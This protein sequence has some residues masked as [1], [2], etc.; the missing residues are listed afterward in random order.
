MKPNYTIIIFSIFLLTACSKSFTDLSPVSQRNV[1]V[2]Y[3]TSGDMVTAINA[4]Y[5]ALQLTGTYNQGY[6]I[7]SE[8][9][10]D[11]TDAGNDVSGGLGIDLN[12]VDNF[13]EDET[14]EV[15]SSVYFDS[16]VGIGRA[17]IVLSRIDAVP[18]DETL[19]NRIK[20]EALFLRALFYYNLAIDFGRV[21]FVLKEIPVEEGKSYPQVAASEIY[22]QLIPDLIQ[23]ETYLTARYTATEVGRATKGAAATLLAKI[24]LTTGDK[25]SA[26]PVLRRIISTYGYTLLPDYSRLWGVANENN[27]ESIFEV[28]F[29]GGGFGTGNLFTNT[30]SALLPHSTGEYKNRP[31]ASLQAAFE[32]GDKRVASSFNPLNGPL[33]VNRFILKYGTTNGFTE[34]DGDYNFV[35]FRYADVYLLLAEALGESAESYSLIN[36]LRNPR[37]GLAPISAATPG[38]F[39]DKLL[40]E[41]QVEL[42][43]ENHRW[44]D[45]LRF[46]KATTIMTAQGKTPRLLF[47]IPRRELDINKTF[48]QNPK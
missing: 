2:F 9:R 41:R 16:Y 15:V 44:P 48:T 29:K 7:T 31:T 33:N 39:E 32:P 34:F 14:S 24:Y 17:N 20:G 46:G 47:L 21:P 13:K 12:V 27:A 43:F 11:N 26:V 1:D 36:S 22:K 28:Q 38:S 5:K 6:W 18:M 10:S 19:K 30:F 45:L 8:L 37:A 35:V 42:A 40:H 23:A 3:R 25:A 4:T